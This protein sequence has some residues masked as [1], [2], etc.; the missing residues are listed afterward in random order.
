[1]GNPKLHDGFLASLYGDL[2]EI[3]RE[4]GIKSGL[5]SDRDKSPLANSREW[6]LLDWNPLDWTHWANMTQEPR[7]SIFDQFP[8]A[9]FSQESP[10]RAESTATH[11]VVNQVKE[12][13]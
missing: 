2:D 13:I 4:W 12:M 9:V 11:M 10:A 1:M 7:W 3:D 6:G 8:E 5:D